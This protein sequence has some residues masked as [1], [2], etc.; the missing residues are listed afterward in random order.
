MG[1]ILRVI[2]MNITLRINMADV[3]CFTIVLRLILIL[4]CF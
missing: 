2:H 1:L 3:L 4:T